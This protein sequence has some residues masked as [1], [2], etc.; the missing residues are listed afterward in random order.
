MAHNVEDTDD[1]LEADIAEFARHNRGG[2]WALA[3]LVARRV[4]PDLGHG[5]S[6]EQQDKL[7]DR[8]VCRQISAVEFA[9]RSKTSTKRVLALHKAWI[10]GAEAGKVASLEKVVAG[11]Y[12]K[13][14]DEDDVPFYGEH[15]FY[16][17]HESRMPKGERRDALETEAE[18]AGVRP[19]SPVFVA[20]HPKAVK[21]AV[22]ADEAT[23]T[24]ALEGIA[25]V[26][27]REAKEQGR[28]GRQAAGEVADSHAR[29]LDG[30]AGNWSPEGGEE[31]MDPAAAVAAVR[32][33]AEPGDADAALQVFNE[34][35]QVRLGTLRVL[36]LLQRHPVQFSDDRGRTITQLC[37]ATKA[38]LDFARDLVASP[39]AVLDDAALRAFLEESEK[40]G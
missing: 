24:A 17:S 27:R 23:R 36:S 30:R 9:R 21:A 39:Y 20:Q 35:A 38:A 33:T 3:L 22:I 2:G 18:R 11:E 4:E 7:F 37:E 19:S 12:V 32:A 40:L 28:A 15:G 29:E 31:G 25:E 16:K 13:L 14:P 5:L 34:L 26:Q 6:F 10:R 1:G 8:K